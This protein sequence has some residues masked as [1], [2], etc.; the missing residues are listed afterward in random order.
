[1]KNY[2][3]VATAISM[4]GT[5]TLLADYYHQEGG[6]YPTS[7]YENNSWG[8]D[9]PNY[10][11]TPSYGEQQSFYNTSAYGEHTS[12]RG[13][14][15][16]PNLYNTPSSGQMPSQYSPSSGMQSQ[17]SPGM[18]AQHMQSSGTHS[19]YYSQGNMTGAVTAPSNFT[20]DS[21]PNAQGMSPNSTATQPRTTSGAQMSNQGIVKSNDN[22]KFTTDD[23][24]RLGFQIRQQ[25]AEKHPQLD[26]NTLAL[27]VDDGS[28]RISG[29]VRNEQDR[30]ALSNLIKELKG[31]KSVNNKLEVGN[32]TTTS[33]PNSP[34][35]VNETNQKYPSYVNP[36]QKNTYPN[37]T[38]NWANSPA[39]TTNISGQDSLLADKIRQS[40][41]SDNS[42]SPQAKSVG[43]LVNS[44]TITLNGTVKSESEKNRLTAKIKGMSEGRLVNNMLEVNSTR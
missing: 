6:Y 15:Q 31:V 42:L 41:A 8:Y 24:R 32:A 19:Q 34:L 4:I 2:M 26:L 28:V 23:D 29:R 11:N 35:A 20:T 3:L 30:V 7:G 21:R 27:Y 43:I 10:Y 1:M 17:Y 18:Q 22:D 44:K 36:Q 14:Y 37:S 33:N 5:G 39:P 16:Q 13:E 38:S 9:Q 40:I 12:G 25:I